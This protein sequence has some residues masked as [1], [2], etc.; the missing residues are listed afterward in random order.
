MSSEHELTE[1][2]CALGEALELLEAAKC[3]NA[4]CVDGILHITRLGDVYD[5][6]EPCQWCAEKKKLLDGRY[7]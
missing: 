2:R 1:V 5:E 4:S 6:I 7:G 3:P